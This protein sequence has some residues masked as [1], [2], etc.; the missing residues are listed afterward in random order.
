MTTSTGAAPA[1]FPHL[2]AP[3]PKC[4]AEGRSLVWVPAAGAIADGPTDAPLIRLD[5]R[6]HMRVTCSVCGFVWPA[7]P[8]DASEV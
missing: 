2:S 8:A 3:C 4:G 6:E 1:S 7:A 5:P